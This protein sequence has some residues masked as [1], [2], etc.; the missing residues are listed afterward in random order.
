MAVGKNPA[1]TS[2]GKLPPCKWLL[3]F[4]GVQGFDPIQLLL[5]LLNYIDALNHS[6]S[7]ELDYFL[8]A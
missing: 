2:W 7:F 5:A 3:R 4:I 6:F 1:G 8:L